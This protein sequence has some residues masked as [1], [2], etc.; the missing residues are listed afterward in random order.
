MSDLN[1]F[2]DFKNSW[3]A[4]SVNEKVEIAVKSDYLTNKGVDFYEKDD[5]DMAIYYFELVLK[6]MPINDDALKNLRVCYRRKHLQE[7]L[8][9]TIQKLRILGIE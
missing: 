7:K 4:L 5:I 1:D 9:I 2:I 6:V 8:D 3:N